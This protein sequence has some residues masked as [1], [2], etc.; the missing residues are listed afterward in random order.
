MFICCSFDR[1]AASAF[2]PILAMPWGWGPKFSPPI[3]RLGGSQI[4]WKFLDPYR[5][6]IHV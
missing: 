4:L 6:K 3:S 2:I 1:C 5:R